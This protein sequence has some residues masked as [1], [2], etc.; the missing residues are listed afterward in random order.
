MA[1]LTINHYVNQVNNFI[2]NIRDTKRNYYVFAARSYPWDNELSPPDANNST[3][4]Y[5]QTIYNDLLFGKRIASSDVSAMI[6]KYQWTYNTSYY[7]Y[8]QNDPTLFDNNFY[9]INDNLEVYKCLSNSTGNSTV[10]PILSSASGTFKTA[11]GYIWKYMYTIDSTTSKFISTNYIPV[12]TNTSVQL[13]ATPGSI[14]IIELT[15]G[16]SGYLAYENGFI[17]KLVD[18]QTIQLPTSSSSTDNFYTNSSIYLKSGFGAGQVREITSYNGVTKRLT[19]SASNPFIT[20]TRLELSGVS[21]GTNIIPGNYVSQSIDYMPY[22]NSVG[23]PNIKA[24]IVQTDVGVSGTIVAAN[25]TVLQITK[26]L[27]TSSFSTNLPLIDL[28]YQT[29]IGTTSNATTANTNVLNL[30]ILLFNGS[31]YTSNTTV[32]IT[33]NGTGSAGVANAQANSTGKISNINIQTAGSLY[34]F[35]PTVSIPS[36]AATSFNASTSVN[37]TTSKITLSSAGSFVVNDPIIYYTAAGN[38]VISGLSNNTQYFVQFADATTIALSAT[39]GGAKI[40]LIPGLSQTGHYLQGLTATGRIFPDNMVVTLPSGTAFNSNFSVGEYI[41]VG[42]INPNNNIRRISSVNSS[43]ITVNFPFFSAITSNVAYKMPVAFEPSGVTVAT[44]ANGT[45]TNTNIQAVSLLITNSNVPGQTFTVGE[46]V[47]LVDVSGV[48]QSAS[49]YVAYSNTTAAYLSGVTGSNWNDSTYWTSNY[50]IK[51]E[52]SLIQYNIQS[53]TTNPNITIQNQKGTFALGQKMI[54]KTS[55]G[56]NTGSYANLTG[57]FLIPNDN[58]EYEIGPTVKIT[59]DGSNATAIGVVNTAV[60]SN[61]SVVGI[62]MIN[63]G[64]NYT[65]ANVS[66]YANNSQGSGAT[67]YAAISPVHGHG[68]DALTELGARYAG[69]DTSFDIVSTDGYY[70]PSYGSYRKVGIIQDPQFNDVQVTVNSFD[71]AIL[72]LGSGSGSS[73]TPNEVVVQ[74]TSLA[75]GVVVFGN[76]SYLQLKSVHGTF[77]TSTSA[78]NQIYGYTS[79]MTGNLVSY[80]TLYFIPNGTSEIISEVTSG[81]TGTVLSI[82]PGTSNTGIKL[83]NVA[84][85]FANNDVMFDPVVNAYATVASIKTANGSKNVTNSFGKYFNQ[86]ARITLTSN[87]GAFVNNEL[88]IQASSNAIGKIVSTKNEVDIAITGPTGAFSNGSVV[89]DTTT[90]ANGVVLFANSSYIK[91]TDV[92]DLLSFTGTTINNGT[93]SATVSKVYPVLTVNDTSSANPIRAGSSTFVG[94]TSLATGTCSNNDFISYGDLV[95]DS[96]KVIYM[97]NIQ[98]ITRSRS[99]KEEF[100]IVIKF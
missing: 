30:G 61:Y 7:A 25:N 31:G 58:T 90:T 93:Y 75:S 5:E 35:E 68:Y 42:N 76:N 12:A 16:G 100:K 92:S 82:I 9:V 62:E 54:V 63:T 66:I 19:V 49:G 22:R 39:L 67:S 71:R 77:V 15:N 85:Q 34:K 2:S 64:S 87:T 6:P 28:N 45:I 51:G 43:I 8:N 1:L 10:Q 78:C 73:W 84:G 97:E 21:G 24:A 33:A 86:T 37:G 13:N 88:I 4:Q 11:D 96:G 27:E 59:G 95:R 41:R 99:T 23:Y 29:G 57:S 32:T 83:T 36:P 94:Q 69:I 65:Y 98:P 26:N 52:S 20:F 44:F 72:N 91:L 89:Y 48:T 47:D 17:T 18:S 46:K 79:N 80:N 74:G 3:A 50:F 60:G 40:T 70:N 56:F 38:T 53:A 14:D 55:T 81:A